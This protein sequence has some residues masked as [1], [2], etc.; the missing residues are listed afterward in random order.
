MKKV[1]YHEAVGSLMYATVATRPD[2]TFAISTLSQFLENP[3]FVHWEA[4]KRV[5][6]YLSGTKTHALTYGNERHDLLGY[7]D[8]DSASQ[9]HRH[10]ILGYAFLIDSATISWASRKQELVTLSTAEAKYVATM[11][12]AKECIWLHRLTSQLFGHIITP[13]TLYCNNQAAIHLAT[14][15]NYHARTKHIDIRFH[16][17]HQTITDGAISIEYCPTQDMTAD[18]LTKA[19]P[20]H[21]V[22]IHSQNLGICRT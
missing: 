21:K 3:G 9:D 14:D 13:T 10:A 15:D 7:T 2:I 19:L 20:K 16:F 5:L 22:A 1:P 8:A 11:H 12:A 18:I 4:V 17:I 6:R